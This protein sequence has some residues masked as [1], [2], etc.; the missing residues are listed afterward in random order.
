[1][2]PENSKSRTVQ[3]TRVPPPGFRTSLRARLRLSAL[4]GI[5]ILGA[6]LAYTVNAVLNLYGVTLTIQRTTDLRERVQ[7]SLAGLGEAQEALD[8][9]VVSGQGYDLSRHNSGRTTLHM[10]LGAISRRVL[11]EGSRGLVQRAEVAEEIYAK[12]ADSALKAFRVEDPAGAR[13]MRDSSVTPTAEKLRDVLVELQAVF[14]RTESLAEERLKNSRDAAATSLVLLAVLI[15]AGILWHL[16]D[17][18]RRVLIPCGA[19]AKALEDLAADRTPPRLF[20]QSDDE[21]GELGRNFN[22]AA[23]LH[24]ERSRALAERDIQASVNA[25]LAAAATVNDLA[26]FGSKVLPEILRVSGASSGVLYLPSPDGGF[27]PA[28]S[29]GGG[30]AESAVG[31]EEARRAAEERRTLFISVEPATPTINVY[32][33]RI[34]PRESLT[35]PLV[36]FD[37]VVGVLALGAAQAFTAPARNALSAIAPSL[38]VAVANASANERVAEQSRRLAEQNELLE[39]QRSRITRTAHELQRASEL[40]D[41]FLASV[42]HELRTPMTVILGFTGALLRGGQGQ[43]TPPQKES[44][45]RV[46]RNARMLLRLINDVLDISR[47]EAGKM[48]IA[49]QRVEVATV[50]RQVEADFTDAAA[51]KG[52]KLTASVAPGLSPVT[53]DPAR[54]TQI[55]AN[56]VGNSL[57][58]TDTGSIDI[59]AEPRG[60]ERWALVVSD[61]GIGI[62]EEEQEAVFEEFRQGEPEEH[63]G[64]GGTGLGLAIS[65]KLA[66]ALGGTISLESSRGKGSRFTILLPR[67]WNEEHARPRA[68]PIALVAPRPGQKSVLIVDDDEGVRELLAFEL[69]PHGVRIF[70]ASDGKEGLRVAVEEKPDAILLDVLMPNVD[71]WQVLRTLKENPETRDIPVVIVS[72]VENRAFGVSLGAFDHLVKPVDRTALLLTLS[73]AGALAT[74]GPIL[75][76]DDDPDVRTLLEHELVSAGYRVRAAAGGS[77]ALEML[78]REKPSAMLLDLSMPPPDGFEVLYRIRQDPGLADLPV[79]VVTAR[80]LS[81]SEQEA[82]E[83]STSRILRKGSDATL[84]VDQILRTIE[85]ESAGVA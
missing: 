55:L 28:A 65:R 37:H 61:T 53:T 14:T 17:L 79:I 19:A 50:L 60:D 13:A 3:R 85:A 66:H 29:L 32:D 47:I 43:L 67:E 69:K 51:R 38:A 31:R 57:K 74:R 15:L 45:E 16:S 7:D 68:D 12:T 83:R 46:Q 18:N 77:E 40:K 71:G 81:R 73:R 54:L 58:F 76:V 8:R 62:P 56:L 5:A 11:T 4:I 80:E 26:G 21:I 9:Y 72:V 59:V 24:A 44:L 48:E 52:L 1:M 27:L 82:L 36:Y 63:R 23:K 70:Q 35:I 49:P 34:L 39:E 20:D 22:K 33:G 25:V 78:R 64:R 41:R 84:L 75:V 42:S 30:E 2:T 6:W 10:A